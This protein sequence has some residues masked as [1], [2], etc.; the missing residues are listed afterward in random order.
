MTD[1]TTADHD[2]YLPIEMDSLLT[3]LC[4]RFPQAFTPYRESTCHPLKRGIYHD[5]LA[6]LGDGI[7]PVALSR[8]L[9]FYTGA[10]RYR[11]ALVA[12]AARIDLDG[13]VAGEV[14]ESEA[15]SAWQPRRPHR[16]R[17]A[18]PKPKPP[19][20]VPKPPA[21]PPQPA[22]QSRRMSLA[23][24]KAAAQRRRGG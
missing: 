13:N 4:A 11:A 14:T 7:D 1:T 19:P 12:G 16:S 3:L 17:R 2:G 8:V 23:D 6:R 24:L 9:A 20:Q 18:K 5:I 22:A 21:P 15:A 10:H